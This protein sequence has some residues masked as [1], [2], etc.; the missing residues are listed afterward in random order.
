VSGTDVLVVGVDSTAGWRAATD[1]LADSLRRAGAAVERVGAGPLRRV[2]TF[3]LTDYV[4]ARAARQVCQRA[5]AAHDPATII[6]ASIN[7]ALLWPRPGAVFLDSIAAENRPGRHGFW[8]RPVER[9]RLRQT[10]L[11]LAWSERSLEALRGPHA[12]M[13]VTSPPVSIAPHAGKDIDAITYAGDPIKRRL[14]VVLD[15][16]RSA[17]KDG[18]TLLLTGTDRVEA[19]PGVE[20][21]GR[22]AP[23]AFR[24]LLRR[25][26]VFLAA[27]CREDYGIAALEALACGCLLVTTPSPGPYPALELAR[28][29][30]PRL[31][32]H[33]LPGPI[34]CAL[35]DPLC[36]YAARAAE[37]LQPFTRESFDVTVAN[38]VL[39]RLLPA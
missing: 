31:V 38:E 22:V 29:L 28:R 3:A 11:V 36:G 24:A 18:E 2:R 5:I 33:D 35:D 8:Q 9:R 14:D 30:D 23:D 10:S 4:E 20:V 27:P 6:Y 16:W 7:A 1:E 32:A 17:R 15:A 26:K 21:A 25:S 39:P 19:L 13:V 12:Q 37:M 34:R